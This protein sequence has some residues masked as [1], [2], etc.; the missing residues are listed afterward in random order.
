MTDLTLVAG[1]GLT[2][3]EDGETLTV[4]STTGWAVY[5]DTVYT[6]A[7]PLSIVGGAAYVN[8]PNNSGSVD[9]EFKPIDIPSL[10]TGGK[11]TGINGETRQI[12]VS[13]GIKP[14]TN[15]SNPRVTVTVDIG[16]AIGI[17]TDYSR[18]F[19]MSRGKDN[20]H[21]YLSSFTVFTRDTWEA[22]GG[23]LK[24]KTTTDCELYNVRVLIVAVTR[25]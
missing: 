10:F 25:V 17:L 15:V 9:D 24:I 16:G 22:N 2:L 4:G 14:T 6:E 8:L 18:D 3:I 21:R 12:T 7:S 19:T 20:E 23:Q 1:S 11:I 13:F 5:R